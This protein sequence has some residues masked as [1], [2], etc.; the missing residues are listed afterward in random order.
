MSDLDD[1]LRRIITDSDL[2]KRQWR[3]LEQKLVQIKQ[4][5][6]E[7]GYTHSYRIS[8]R[9]TPLPSNLMTGDY[10]YDRFQV[11]VKRATVETGAKAKFFR[12]H[13]D[14]EEAKAALTAWAGEAINRAAG[15][16]AGIS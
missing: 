2:P 8:H 7:E 15:R 10:W 5:F 3:T 1:K 16:A 6:A 12:E 14:P 4:V 13:L 9:G 11:E